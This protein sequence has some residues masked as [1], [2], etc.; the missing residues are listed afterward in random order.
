MTSPTKP[1]TRGKGAMRVNLNMK[2]KRDICLYQNKNPSVK[3]DRLA[4]HF[5]AKWGI[6]LSRSTVSRILTDKAKFIAMHLS[7]LV[8][9]FTAVDVPQRT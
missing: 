7:E 6:K 5:S 8:R 1:G 4:E 3:Q 9:C 2:Q